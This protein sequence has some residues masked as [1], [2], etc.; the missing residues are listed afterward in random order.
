MADQGKQKLRMAF[1]HLEREMPQ[2]MAQLLRKLRHPDARWFRIPAGVLLIFGGIF[3]ILPVL[4]LWMLPLGL[5]LIAYDVPFLREPMARFTIWGAGQ[6][7]T[8]RQWLAR[9]GQPGG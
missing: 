9:R 3:S 8:F 7:A 4:G 1:R 5:L 2:S 6:W